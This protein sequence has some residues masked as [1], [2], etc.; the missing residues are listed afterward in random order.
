MFTWL[1]PLLA[2][3]NVVWKMEG[4][5]G[6][7]NALIQNERSAM[8]WMKLNVNEVM[9]KTQENQS[10]EIKESRIFKKYYYY[11]CWNYCKFPKR[12]IWN[13]HN[14]NAFCLSLCCVND[15]SKVILDALQKMFCMLMC[16][17]P[18]LYFLLTQEQN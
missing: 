18:I 6:N 11:F 8:F 13:L 2:L 3:L 4:F 10:L 7:E 14:R 15:N 17:I 12:K 1:S 5:S 9:K 16:Y